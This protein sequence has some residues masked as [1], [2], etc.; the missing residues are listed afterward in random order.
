MLAVEPEIW[1]VLICTALTLFYS[2]AHYTLRSPSR[3][4]LEAAFVARNRLGQLEK[5]DR[6]LDM[7]LLV[8]ATVRTLAHL[9]LTLAIL[10]LLDGREHWLGDVWALLV[11][12]SIVLVFGVGVPDAWAKYAGEK[13][14]AATW[15]V[16]AGSRVVFWP[17]ARG[18]YGLDVLVRRLSGHREET[19]HRTS[20]VE[21]EIL[22]LATEGE[23]EGTVDPEELEMIESVIEFRDMR[24]GE[25]MTP[26]TDIVAIEAGSTL[27]QCRQ[28]IVQAGHSRLPVYEETLD[29]VIGVLYA[30][31]LL[32]IDQGDQHFALR[33]TMRKP[34]FVPETKSLSQLLK[35]F[36]TQKVHIAIVL[37]EYGGT[38]GL[39]TIE[40]LLEEIVGEIA[41][42]YEPAE[43]AMLRKI[44]E[45][46]AEV[47]ARMYIDDVN[48]ALEIE[49]P[50][51]EDYDT[52]GGFVFSTLGYIPTSGEAFE[53]AGAKFTVVEAEERRVGRVRIELPEKGPQRAE[54]GVA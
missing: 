29:R 21:Q 5:L 49:L 17:L 54:E 45:H 53:Y 30:K 15:P 31:D 48:D 24:A 40:D 50:E 9:V 23:A 22:Q 25:I 46:T 44:D 1:V 16:L 38:A 26:R 13:T 47:D 43:P 32:S 8:T 11:A 20:V 18:L 14:V 33:S 27:D 41:D 3:V 42:E 35:E 34:F 4:R 52:V 39:V 6:H 19:N 36:K 51:D 10:R 12:G 2:V 7:L 28:V 37:D